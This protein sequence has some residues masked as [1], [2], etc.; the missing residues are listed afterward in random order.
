MKKILL[1]YL[2]ALCT[3]AT[4]LQAQ[5]TNITPANVQNLT[6]LSVVDNQTAVVM[7]TDSLNPLR[8]TKDG[9]VSWQSLNMPVWSDSDPLYWQGV[10]FVSEQTG[11]LYGSWLIG[12]GLYAGGTENFILFKT[13]DGGNSWTP[14]AQPIPAEGF[15]SIS[16]L[17]FFNANQGVVTL[18]TGLGYSLV[19]TSDDGGASWQT[20]DT[21]TY[22]NSAEHFT[23]D[24]NG[25]AIRYRHDFQNHT[26][27]FYL[28][29]IADFGKTWTEVGVPGIGAAWLELRKG[30]W[31][32]GILFV[33]DAVAYRIR[34]EQNA[35]GQA[36]NEHFLDKSTDG[37]TTWQENY[38]TTVQHN[39]QQLVLDQPNPWI[40]TWEKLFR[41]SSSTATEALP[42]QVPSM[43]IYPNPVLAGNT[44]E[45]QTAGDYS[46]PS[47]LT[48]Y[49]NDGKL[50]HHMS[51]TVYQ[52][53]I[54]V[55]V[56][57][58]PAGPY[59]LQLQALGKT[60]GLGRVILL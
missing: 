31:F 26:N 59:T 50:V 15:A 27:Q 34:T 38:F 22:W 14:L 46:G 30:L 10:Q 49:T 17:H 48:F 60:I 53:K 28:Y 32:D 52:G 55:K 43:Q 29:T 44:L 47:L 11:F 20:R 3:S 40:L 54:T 56:P 4:P 21:L 6:A 58:L 8:Q 18:V 1:F 12:G 57:A 39:F 35:L 7:T 41:R 25:V 36:D 19:K 16:A 51:F 23:P 5:W 37:G 42:N 33:D 9:G 45:L 24:G 13:T 2:A